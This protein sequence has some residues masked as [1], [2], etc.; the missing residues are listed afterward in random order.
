MRFDLLSNIVRAKST[1]RR[2]NRLT[3]PQAAVEVL[4]VREGAQIVFEIDSATKQGIIRPLVH[5][6]SGALLGVFGS[7]EEAAAYI[8]GGRDVWE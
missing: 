7:P 2:P 8:Q 4:G 3:L 5:S 1:I 6:Y